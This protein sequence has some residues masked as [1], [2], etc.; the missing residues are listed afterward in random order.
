MGGGHLGGR[1]AHREGAGGVGEV[2]PEPAAEVGDDDIPLLDDTVGRLVVRRGTVGPRSDD[3]EG[4]GVVA[5]LDQRPGDDPGQVA[6][7]AAGEPRPGQ[8]RR[9]PVG[10]GAGGGEQR[11]LGLVL[12]QSHRADHGRRRTEANIG[13]RILEGEQEAGPGVIADGRHAHPHQ[14]VGHQVDGCSVSPQAT[15]SQ[16][17]GSTSTRAPRARAPGASGDPRPG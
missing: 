13:H 8:P 1:I 10:G 9:H 16:S 17:V 5:L 15:V 11:D 12:H 14:P 2:P 6:L 7:G 4:G 3:G